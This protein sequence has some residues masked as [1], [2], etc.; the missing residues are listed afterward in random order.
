MFSAG[1]GLG[2]GVSIA[3]D[4]G[5]GV[6]GRSG[7]G[8]GSGFSRLEAEELVLGRGGVGADPFASPADEP[9]MEDDGEEDD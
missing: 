6:R 1:E 7:S 5:G 8:V 4:C 3:N 9:V 2:P